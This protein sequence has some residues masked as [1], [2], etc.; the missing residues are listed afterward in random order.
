MNALRAM[1]RLL[2][3]KRRVADA[4]E[5]EH[6]KLQLA[7][8]HG[9]QE[10]ESSEQMWHR[11]AVEKPLV[12]TIAD[13]EDH[14]TSVRLLRRIADATAKQLQSREAACMEAL[15]KLTEARREVTRY[16][17]WLERQLEAQAEEN[18]RLERL[19]EDEHAARKRSVA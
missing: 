13:L 4:A 7:L 9:R 3:I 15:A 1:S 19:R 10:A 11:L 18:R 6:A 14:V 2:D 16:E 8:L 17:M 12:K 5:A